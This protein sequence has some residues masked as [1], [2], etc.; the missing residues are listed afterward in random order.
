MPIQPV[1]IQRRMMELGRVRLG[2]K[3]AKGEPKKLTT[4]RFTSASRPLLEAIAE[5]HGGTVQPWTGAP[6]EGYFEVTTNTDHIDIVLPPVFSDTDGTP[7]APYSQFFELWSGGGCQ[8]RCD[9]V[10]EL[11][12]GTP[13]KCLAD[14]QRAGEDARECNVT[15]RVSFMLPDIPGL[16]VWRLESHGY[17]AAVELP[18]TLETLQL[19]AS[20]HTFIPAVL[21][22]EQRTKKIPGQ[23]TRR[24]VVPVIDLPNV[25][26]QQLASGQVPQVL[27]APAGTRR[28]RPELPTA[29]PP[30]GGGDLGTRAAAEF[31]EPPGLP[32]PSGPT[33]PEA[34][35]HGASSQPDDE[36]EPKATEDDPSTPV[37]SAPALHVP[38]EIIREAGNTKIP[39]GKYRGHTI[40][41][42]ASTLEGTDWFRAILKAKDSGT[43][44][45][46]EVYAREF[47]PDLWRE[48]EESLEA[49]GQ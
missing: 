20:E 30:N 44:R 21:R 49:H 27:N 38:I 42:I 25:T 19:A 45:A 7:T 40:R 22:A 39:S 28:A 31:G 9:G 23:G 47:L 4:L 34:A 24:Y 33:T 37:A 3:G 1:A 15:T 32:S 36:Q 43:R 48:Y 29:E 13:C 16:G 18:G 12:T 8:R 6:D 14:V 41:D 26:V 2:E 35:A 46:A 10:T 11:L 5:K 17:N